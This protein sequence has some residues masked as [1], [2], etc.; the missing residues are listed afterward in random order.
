MISMKQPIDHWIP[1]LLVVYELNSFH[2]IDSGRENHS[3]SINSILISIQFRIQINIP[4]TL[5]EYC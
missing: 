5:I 1:A 3:N 2:L 4:L